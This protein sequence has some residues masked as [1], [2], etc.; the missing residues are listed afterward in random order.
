MA[1]YD[2]IGRTYSG[3]RRPDDRIAA[4]IHA[5]LGAEAAVANVGAGTGSYENGQT[6]VAIE[7]SAVMIAQRPAGAAPAVR[8][9]AE[10][11][12]LAARAVDTVTAFLTVHHWTDLDAGLAELRRIARQR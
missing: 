4:R 10:S 5:C 7:P 1:L 2:T 3:V 11:I 6:V 12:P 8:A 9:R